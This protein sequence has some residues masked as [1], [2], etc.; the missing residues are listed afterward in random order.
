V[1]SLAVKAV[2]EK[3]RTSIAGTDRGSG[4]IGFIDDKFKKLGAWARKG[5]GKVLSSKDHSE[6]ASYVD[7]PS[8]P[9][10]DSIVEARSHELHS[11]SLHDIRHGS[12]RAQSKRIDADVRFSCGQVVLEEQAGPRHAKDHVTSLHVR[13]WVGPLDRCAGTRVPGPAGPDMSQSSARAQRK[14]PARRPSTPPLLVCRSGDQPAVLNE[15]DR[16]LITHRQ[17][18]ASPPSSTGAA[19]PGASPLQVLPVSLC[20]AGLHA[21][22]T[23]E[24]QPAPSVRSWLA[25]RRRTGPPSSPPAALRSVSI[26]AGPPESI[27][28]A[29]AQG[30]SWWR[31]DRDSWDAPA[32]VTA[33]GNQPPRSTA[34]L[35]QP[36]R[37]G[38]THTQPVA[39][40]RR[41]AYSEHSQRPPE[42]YGSGVYHDLIQLS[43]LSRSLYPTHWDAYSSQEAPEHRR[44]FSHMFL[45]SDDPGLPYSCLENPGAVGSHHC[46][47]QIHSQAD[48]T[49]TFSAPDTAPD[50]GLKLADLPIHVPLAGENSSYSNQRQIILCN[51][52]HGLRD[53]A[54]LT[55]LQPVTAPPQP[56]PLSPGFGELMALEP[57]PSLRR[58]R[59]MPQPKSGA[60]FLVAMCQNS[61]DS[62][63]LPAVTVNSSCT[64]APP[65]TAAG[66]TFKFAENHDGAVQQ[67]SAG[68][69]LGRRSGSLRDGR[70][71]SSR[72]Q[73][74]CSGW[75]RKQDVDVDERFDAY[76]VHHPRRHG[77]GKESDSVQSTTG[78]CN[79]KFD[80]LRPVDPDGVTDAAASD[81]QGMTPLISSVSVVVRGCSSRPSS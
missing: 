13:P 10:S 56:L 11:L 79:V 43:D 24:P 17:A 46:R 57:R 48:L 59:S 19:P 29:P 23:P 21:V 16:Y 70:G 38:D 27:T 20:G 75:M 8:E 60:S 58:Y 12:Q 1:Y 64:H 33:V 61:Q 36:P 63:D 18:L 69:G 54:T 30:T 67:R 53:A 78:H 3:K 35:S 77:Q 32:H 7:L 6:P 28:A 68:T 80:F 50:F 39:T 5:I 15:R 45:T 71:G 73:N 22:A 2:E 47:K 76:S 51:P 55:D 52:S 74:P 44:H 14:S 9:K 81:K 66:P 25:E 49:R 31:A 72:R 42:V 40:Y 62:Q 34:E 65:Q 26:A 41:Q 37:I 4:Q